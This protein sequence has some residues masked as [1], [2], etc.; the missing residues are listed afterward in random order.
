MGIAPL[1][2]VGSEYKGTKVLVIDPNPIRGQQHEVRTEVEKKLQ[3]VDVYFVSTLEE[4]RDSLRKYNCNLAIFPD[5][6][7]HHDFVNIQLELKH[8]NPD[9]Q[10]I[11]LTD[12]P[13]LDQLRS[14]KKIGGVYDFAQPA[15]LED[16]NNICSVI[17]N[18]IRDQQF[19]GHSQ[20]ETFEFTNVLQKCLLIQNPDWRNIKSQS[21]KVA[22]SLVLDFDFTNIEVTRVLAAEQIFLPWLSLNDYKSILGSDRFGLLETLSCAGT[23]GQNSRQVMNSEGFVVSFSNWIIE[24]ILAGFSIDDIYTQIQARPL[25]IKHPS[26][27]LITR[28]KLAELFSQQLSLVRNG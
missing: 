3:R 15:T 1:K 13:S 12:S 21:Q 27:Q 8:I 28:D 6:I 23:W 25:H 17:I 14:S 11:V 16:F 5:G 10:M 22:S 2:L 7:D 18:F 4:G 26:I 9:L 20:T 19:D 24:V